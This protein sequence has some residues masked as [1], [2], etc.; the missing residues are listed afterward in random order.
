MEGVEYGQYKRS[1]TAY[2]TIHLFAYCTLL[3]HK[4]GSE[5]SKVPC[6]TRSRERN[7]K[8]RLSL[9][10]LIWIRSMARLRRDIKI[11]PGR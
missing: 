5:V 11:S 8:T 3:Q 10:S 4:L 6:A 9:A 1:L 7:L 2:L